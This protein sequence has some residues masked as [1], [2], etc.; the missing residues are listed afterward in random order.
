M[1]TSVIIGFIT[2]GL[3]ICANIAAVAIWAGALKETTQR[4]ERDIQM[5]QKEGKE[6]LAI[7]NTLMIKMGDLST[8]N[9]ALV[10]NAEATKVVAMG[11][12]EHIRSG[13]PVCPSHERF[14][15]E[16]MA[17]KAKTGCVNHE[18]IL[19]DLTALKIKLGG[20]S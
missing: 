18:K 13:L 15:E 8:I 16:L 7:L 14:S 6:T 11:L 3:L 12:A 17:V 4:H 20:K 1:D 9:L 2:L 19:E 10:S 5:L